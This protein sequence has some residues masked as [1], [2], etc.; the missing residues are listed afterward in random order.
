MFFEAYLRPASD[1]IIIWMNAQ[2]N[3]DSPT[4]HA[5]ITPEIFKHSKLSIV[6]KVDTF[7][8]EISFKIFQKTEKL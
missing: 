2:N 6:I 3:A 4:M 5:V 1:C 8:I 7:V